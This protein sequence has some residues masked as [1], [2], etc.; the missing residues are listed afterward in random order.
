MAGVFLHA[1]IFLQQVQIINYVVLCALGMLERDYEP[2][3]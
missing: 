3:S 1:E 2:A